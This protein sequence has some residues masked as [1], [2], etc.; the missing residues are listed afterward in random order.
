MHVLTTTPHSTSPQVATP[1]AGERRDCVTILAMMVADEV[2]ASLFA[3]R[4]E[5]GPRHWLGL[6]NFYVITRYNRSVNYAMVVHE[7]AQHLRQGRP[8]R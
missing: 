1:P 6:H 4:A 5:A 2:L 8:P 7:L 3:T